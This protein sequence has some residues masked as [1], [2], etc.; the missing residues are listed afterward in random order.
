MLYTEGENKLRRATPAT[1]QIAIEANDRAKRGC[2]CK[3]GASITKCQIHKLNAARSTR[4]WC[5]C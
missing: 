2:G 3:G 1:K 5:V 4:H